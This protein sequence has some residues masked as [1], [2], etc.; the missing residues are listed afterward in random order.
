MNK[1][2]KIAIYADDEIVA[3]AN[4]ES[5]EKYRF[6]E[7]VAELAKMELYV[8]KLEKD[9]KSLIKENDQ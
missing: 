4:L 2:I 8:D 7:A 5:T 9:E 3:T 1:T 6:D